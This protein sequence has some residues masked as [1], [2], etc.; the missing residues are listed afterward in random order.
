MG[1]S[2]LFSR[3]GTATA[4]PAADQHVATLPLG[5]CPTKQIIVMTAGGARYA[6]QRVDISADGRI[7]CRWITSAI[8]NSTSWVTITGTSFVAAA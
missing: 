6:A 4:T 2:G 8:W 1:L 3:T 5:Y 7:T